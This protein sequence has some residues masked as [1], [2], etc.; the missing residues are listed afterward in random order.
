MKAIKQFVE[1]LV[2]NKERVLKREISDME[3]RVI[4]AESGKFPEMNE[5]L[6]LRAIAS[7]AEHRNKGTLLGRQKYI[8]DGEK[9]LRA[10]ILGK[11]RDREGD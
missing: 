3:A 10:I 8:L 4:L 2:K 6:R 7:S 9:Q 11:E 5:E 1:E